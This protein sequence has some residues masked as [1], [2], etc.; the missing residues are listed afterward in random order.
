MV[1]RSA[2]SMAATLVEMT[3][4]LRVVQMVAMKVKAKVEMRVAL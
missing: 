3:A 2:M 4:I 1:V